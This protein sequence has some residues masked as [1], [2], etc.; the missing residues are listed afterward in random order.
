MLPPEI[1]DSSS[2]NLLKNRSGKEKV[3]MISEE[4]NDQDGATLTRPR[5]NMMQC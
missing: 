3:D 4:I 5:I 1:N 2:T